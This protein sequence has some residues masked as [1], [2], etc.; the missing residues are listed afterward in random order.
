MLKNKKILIT[1]GTGSFGSAVLKKLLLSNVKEI[2]IFSRDEKKQ[3]DLRKKYNNKKLK[4][5]IGDVRDYQSVL[6]C[7]RGSDFIFHAAALKQVP[8]CEFHPMESVKT[9]ILGT[10][11]LLEA[12]INC[13]VARVIVLSTDKAVYP[14]NAMGISKAMM[15]KV[16][17]QKS[18]ISHKTVINIT[19]YGNVMGSRGSVIPL[20]LDQ[21]T[22]NQPITITDP[23]MTRFMMSLQD[24]VD[25]VFYAFKHGKSGEIFV[26]KSPATNIKN[27]VIALKKIFNIPSHKTDIIGTR[28]GEKLF[29][30]LLSREE[31]V[32][33]KESKNYY[34]VSPDIRD[35]NYKKFIDK[36]E[37]KI[38]KSIEYNSHNTDNL[39]L[40]TL[41][42][43]LIKQDFIKTI[44]KDNKFN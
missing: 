44:I 19:R 30:V 27:L 29:E 33:A 14:I 16:A 8:S 41:Q 12:A 5:Y 17:I 38:S 40:K 3:D 22:N 25:L 15:E 20:F 28:H 34:C 31:M 42:N 18:R 9:N 37:I 39:D 2:R 26:Q 35:L 36:G 4:F 1:G 43:L 11:N 21:I 6:N 32:R 10:E 13:E 23:N 24:A 7:V